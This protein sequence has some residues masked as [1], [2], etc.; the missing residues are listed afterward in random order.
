MLA[1]V[2]IE[3]AKFGIKLHNLPKGID[4]GGFTIAFY[5]MIIATAILAGMMMAFHEAKR[6]GQNVDDYI[7][8]AMVIIVSCIIGARAYYVIFDWKYYS[9]HLDEIINIRQGGLAIYGA[10]IVAFAG[11]F[12]FSRVRKIKF[13]LLADTAIPGLILGQII[14]RWGNFF[15][16]EAF[17]NVAKDSNPLAMRL[18]FDDYFDI[19]DVPDVVLSQMKEI[20]GKSA[21]ELGYVQVQP[22][23]LY[24]SVLNMIVL[25]CMI[26]IA[27][28]YKKFDGQVLLTY[29]LGYGIVRC[30]VEGMRTDQLK[31]PVTGWPVS[32]VLSIVFIILAPIL[33]IFGIFYHQNEKSE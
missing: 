3:F 8:F 33:M 7:D 9:R 31:M 29:L 4:I 22:T 19:N 20:F 5:G 14:G 27:R 12:I 6:T 24:E 1:T 15:N 16:R 17:G 2:S 26:I 18:Y 23:F 21:Y 30:F 11:A 28:K 10:V 13:G 32:Q 25:M